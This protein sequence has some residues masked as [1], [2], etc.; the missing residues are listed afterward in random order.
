MFS[1]IFVHVQVRSF[2]RNNVAFLATRWLNHW[3]IW[4]N[5]S[6]FGHIISGKYCEIRDSVVVEGRSF[7]TWPHVP[8]ISADSE[9]NRRQKPS[10]PFIE[11]ATS[12]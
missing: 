12:Q 11:E 6:L 8:G 2:T 3:F 10:D 5:L 4:G 9:K 1:I 7:G